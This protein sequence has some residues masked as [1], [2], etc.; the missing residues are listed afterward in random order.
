MMMRSKSI[1]LSYGLPPFESCPHVSQ[2]THR[3]PSDRQLS[4][5]SRITEVLSAFQVLSAVY[6]RAFAGTVQ[7]G[8]GASHGPIVGWCLEGH[9][10]L[11]HTAIENLKK[12]GM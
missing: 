3:D 8:E 2:Q 9:R 12:M 11:G 5:I 6:P 1:C 4:S 7:R 10:F